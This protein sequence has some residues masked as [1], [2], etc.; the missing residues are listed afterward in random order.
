M[1]HPFSVTPRAV[2]V[3]LH[4]L[5]TPFMIAWFCCPFESE[6]LIFVVSV[7]ESGLKRKVI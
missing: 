1:S 7:E 6:R 5:I 3:S 4:L 2:I